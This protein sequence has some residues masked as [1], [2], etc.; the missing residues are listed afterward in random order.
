MGRDGLINCGRED[1]RGEGEVTVCGGLKRERRE[2]S[3]RMRREGDD[4]R[5]LGIWDRN[6][7]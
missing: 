2:G 4:S 3:H 5:E 7:E 6:D 1:A